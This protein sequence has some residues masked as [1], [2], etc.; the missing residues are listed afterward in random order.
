MAGGLAIG[1]WLTSNRGDEVSI[2]FGDAIG[3]LAGKKH[4]GDQ[5][6]V[7]PDPENIIY[8]DAG[9]DLLG[10]A[11]GGDDVLVTYGSG[12]LLGD[13]GRAIFHHARGGNDVLRAQITVT[14]TSTPINVEVYGDAGG[15][16]SNHA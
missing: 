1:A 2:V 6:L 8:G 10:Q 13:A 11:Q 5:T 9:Q 16:L 12:N 3:S 4:I 7:G 14:P 15:D